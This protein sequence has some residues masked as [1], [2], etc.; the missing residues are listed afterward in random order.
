MKTGAGI[1]RTLAFAA[2][3]MGAGSSTQS[4]SCDESASKKLKITGTTCLTTTD[5]TTS[6]KV[7]VDKTLFEKDAETKEE[8][9]EG[10]VRRE[11]NRVKEEK[12]EAK[13]VEAKRLE[14]NKEAREGVQKQIEEANLIGKQSREEANRVKVEAYRRPVKESMKEVK[15]EERKRAKEAKEE[16]RKRA[17]EAKEEERKRVKVEAEVEAKRA[18]DAK[19]AMKAEKQENAAPEMQKIPKSRGVGWDKKIMKWQVVFRLDGKKRHGGYFDD[20]RGAVAKEQQLREYG[21]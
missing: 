4:G 10:G 16:G 11:R 13:R 15:E 9:V 17:K 18:K 2:S 14:A 20:H 12:K 19:A 7:D 1:T 6:T 5:F 3:L 21:Q 8:E